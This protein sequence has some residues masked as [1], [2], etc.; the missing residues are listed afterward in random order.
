MLR[1]ARKHKSG[2]Y[3]NI[4]DRW[5]NDDKCRK[6]LSDI[7]WTEEQII[8]YDKITLEDHAYTA[9]RGRKKPEREIMETLTERRR[10]PRT[11]EST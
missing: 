2:C 10:C 1:K 4:L 11:I 3:K 9:T 6:S 7:G 8:Q 5:N